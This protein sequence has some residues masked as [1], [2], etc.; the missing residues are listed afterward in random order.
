MLDED[1]MFVFLF[2]KT[3]LTSLITIDFPS[4]T[5]AGFDLTRLPRLLSILGTAVQ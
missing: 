3:C 1:D 4:G 5:P 2:V